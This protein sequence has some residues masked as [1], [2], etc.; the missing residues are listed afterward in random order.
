[1]KK[2]LQILAVA[3]T[4]AMVTPC[5]AQSI[6]SNRGTMPSLNKESVTY[7][8]RFYELPGVKNMCEVVTPDSYEKVTKNGITTY[9]EKDKTNKQKSLNAESE[10]I[11]VKCIF[12]CDIMTAWTPLRVIAFNKTSHK[13]KDCRPNDEYVTLDLEAG[14]YDFLAVLNKK[15][16]TSPLLSSYDAWVIMEDVEVSGETTLNFDPNTATKHISMRSYNP[17]GELQRIDTVKFN[18]TSGTYDVITYG[19]VGDILVAKYIY[20][21]DYGNPYILFTNLGG[22]EMVYSPWEGQWKGEEWIGDIYVND[23]SDKYMFQEFRT[24]QSKVNE[25]TYYS[26]IRAKC[27][28]TSATNDY[29]KY[30]DPI[31]FKFVN[32]PSREKYD[33]SYSFGE[34]TLSDF[35]TYNKE[36]P[37]IMHSLNG[38]TKKT[39]TIRFCPPSTMPEYDN[40]I[41]FGF[42]F[43]YVDACIDY[44][45]YEE[46]WKV[47]SQYIFPQASGNEWNYS[48]SANQFVLNYSPITFEP[49]DV[50]TGIDGLNFD[51]NNTDL[52]V[53]GTCPIAKIYYYDVPLVWDDG[54]IRLIPAFTIGGYEG[55][56]GEERN[57]DFIDATYELKVDDEIVA[58]NYEELN[59]WSN[60][61]EA[62]APAKLTLS[63]TN[64][65]FKV[66][67]IEGFNDMVIVIDQNKEDHYTPTLTALQFRRADGFVT[68]R[69]EN[70]E[71]GTIAIMCGDFNEQL[72]DDLSYFWFEYGDCDVTV[73]YAPNGT[74]HFT[75]I[76]M[77]KDDSKFHMPGY[78]AY[79]SA[80]LEAFAERSTNGWYDLRITLKDAAGNYQQQ[81]ISPAVRIGDGTP[82]SIKAVES[83]TAT[84]VARYTIDGRAITAP[85]TG[86]NIVKMSDGSVKKVLVK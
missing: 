57:A 7:D 37:V 33:T 9:V 22:A 8:I 62:H 51:Y 45:D 36:L 80:S 68:N 34:V 47:Y 5:P 66:D 20:H 82:S 28:D 58:S 29:T 31:E 77:A 38:L 25:E 35:C 32:S 21:E 64:R 41:D 13:A 3:I 70:A 83:D 81:V 65:N 17:D 52:V 67:D 50:V 79:Y 61:E 73:E 40:L 71:N 4:M 14:T 19:N 54:S 24:T 6:M 49:Y 42:Q 56:M 85:Q 74:D 59:N 69:F 60:S 84:E 78:G 48:Y 39:Y 76:A 75:P 46:A 27:S 10:G 72:R 30:T 1:M 23:V 11:A 15:D 2:I 16:F 43:G 44:G 55:Q 26:V 86:V 53:G 12:D 63:M 18:M